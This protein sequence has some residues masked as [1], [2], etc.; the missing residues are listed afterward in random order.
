[1]SG[2]RKNKLSGMGKAG[3][4]IGIFTDAH[5]PKVEARFGILWT[6]NT[7]LDKGQIV[8]V[9]SRNSLR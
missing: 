8:W 4:T 6:I 1:M 3:D 2:R 5:P 7:P 9:I